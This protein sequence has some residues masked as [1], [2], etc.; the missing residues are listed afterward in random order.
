MRPSSGLCLPR[1]KGLAG[2]EPLK[3]SSIEGVVSKILGLWK[4]HLELLVVVVPLLAVW[5]LWRRE[6]SSRP[7]PQSVRQVELQEG[8]ENHTAGLRGQEMN[9]RIPP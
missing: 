7:F 8:L 1:R 3:V 6:I 2:R 5:V 4:F 9:V